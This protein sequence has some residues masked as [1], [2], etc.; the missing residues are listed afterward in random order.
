MYYCQIPHNIIRI[1]PL[2]D[3]GADIETALQFLNP[4]CCNQMIPLDAPI[5]SAILNDK[6]IIQASFIAWQKNNEILLQ[7]P[8]FM[9][10]GN[11]LAQYKLNTP[12]RIS[13]SND[14][15]IALW[16]DKTPP[17]IENNN[18]DNHTAITIITD[19]R[20]SDLNIHY[21]IGNE[22]D[23]Q[24]YIATHY[25]TA[26]HI[27]E[28]PIEAWQYHRMIHGLVDDEYQHHDFL[29]QHLHYDKLNAIHW[30][31]GCYVGQEIC[32]RIYFKGKVKRKIFPVRF[33]EKKLADDDE[34]TENIAIMNDKQKNVGKIIAIAPDN[35]N[36]IIGLAFLNESA[37]DDMLFCGND[38]SL[39]PILP[40]W[41]QSS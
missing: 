21:L 6:G 12:I 32:A 19:P 18:A 38:V 33:Y 4:L 2:T 7:S 40:A 16:G 3:K 14:V 25:L 36:A 28:Q 37:L 35:P 10:L 29:P 39:I 20:H 9:T 27:T 17:P 30:Q 5:F 41:Y 23:C 34:I 13:K 1:S 11:L 31:K 24:D 26:H 15:I 8:N 22:Q